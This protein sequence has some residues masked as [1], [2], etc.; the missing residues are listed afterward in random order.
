MTSDLTDRQKSVLDFIISHQ[1][2]HQMAPTVREICGHLGLSAPA[3]VHRILNVLKDK[4]YLI[5]EP[6]KKRSWR[7]AGELPG[8]GIPL[9]GEIA[10]GTPL[11][12]IE[13]VGEE[14]AVSPSLFGC[15]ACF[16][17][18]VKGDSMIDAHILDGDIAIIRP[19]RRVET[20]EIAAVMVTELLP[21][22][23]LKRVRHTKASLIL[24]AANPD[25]KSMIFRG[26]KRRR[27]KILGKYVGVVRR[28]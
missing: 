12:A 21:E 8:K 20:G 25:Y 5:A 15:D 10:A 27:V 23:T 3:G 18:K 7:F 19:Q 1:Q 4:G 28:M 16:G 2:E 9:V 6:G 24:E 22:A 17:L 11:E 13:N 26:A 14:L